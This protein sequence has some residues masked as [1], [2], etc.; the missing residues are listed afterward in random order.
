MV[1]Y[2]MA[3][4][5]I[6]MYLAVFKNTRYFIKMI[7]EVIVE[8]KTFILILGISLFAYGQIIYSANV[9]NQQTDANEE[10]HF[11]LSLVFALG[12]LGDYESIGTV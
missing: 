1:M 11:R 9:I 12:E 2:F 4:V 7:I 5:K 10:S 8:I 6:L 3:W